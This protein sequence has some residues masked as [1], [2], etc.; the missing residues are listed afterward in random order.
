MP[1]LTVFF[2][3]VSM[4]AVQYFMASRNSF[5]LGAVIPILFTAV[6]TWMFTTNRIESKIAYIV[7]LLIG[8]IILIEEWVRGRKS[9]RKRQ[10]KEMDIMITKDL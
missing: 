3:I 10:Q 4:S 6:I 9:L 2:I 1:D 5:I 7:L 8:L